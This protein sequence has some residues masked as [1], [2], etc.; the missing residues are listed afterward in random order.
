MLPTWT[1]GTGS[2]YDLAL[3]CTLIAGAVCGMLALFLAARSDRDCKKLRT[4]SQSFA[5]VVRKRWAD[6]DQ[7]GTREALRFQAESA[8]SSWHLEIK[9]TGGLVGENKKLR[10]ALGWYAGLEG[11][12]YP[13]A[14]NRDEGSRARE[15]LKGKA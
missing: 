2:A 15:A 1:A 11:A 3:L 12:V 6:E 13:H 10:A 4:A 14:V 8:L 9:R 7:G 5:D